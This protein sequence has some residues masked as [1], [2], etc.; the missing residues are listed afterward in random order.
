MVAVVRKVGGV[1]YSLTFVVNLNFNLF[2]NVHYDPSIL[3]F[4]IQ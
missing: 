3:L 4:K 1:N 2:M